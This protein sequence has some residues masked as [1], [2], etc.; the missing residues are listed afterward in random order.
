MEA[1]DLERAASDSPSSDAAAALRGQIALLQAFAPGLVARRLRHDH[2]PPREP[3]SE[4]LH[5]AVLFSDISGFT[6]LTERLARRGARGAEDVKEVINGC[7]GPLIDLIA[8]HGGEVEKFAGD[9]T[10]AIWPADSEAE[11]PQAILCAA[12]CCLEIQ[13][14]LDGLQMGE[15]FQLRLRL[16]LTAGSA[17]LATTGGVDGRWETL[18]TGDALQQI[19]PA[20]RQAAPGD[21]VISPEAWDLVRSQA[22]GELLEEGCL[23]LDDLRPRQPPR[24]AAEIAL[25]EEAVE[26]LRSFVP[27]SVQSRFL[28]GQTGWLAEFR[29]VSV[30][31]VRFGNFELKSGESLDRLHRA[32]RGI[33]G[34]IYHFGG[35]VNQLVTDEKGNCVVAA[36]GLPS[37]HY[38]DNAVRAV[39]AALE[40]GETLAELEVDGSLGLATGQIFTGPRGNDR[41]RDYAMIGNAVNLAARLMQSAGAGILSD[42]ATRQAAAKEIVFDRL[43]PILVKGRSSPVDIFRP[44]ALEKRLSKRRDETFGRDGEKE[45]LASRLTELLQGQGSTVLIEGEPGIGKSHLMM[46]FLERAKERGVQVLLGAGDA[47][48][49]ASAFH[50]WRPV[51]DQL[52]GFDELPDA[53]SKRRRYFERLPAEEHERA[54]LL[55]PILPFDLAETAATAGLT[56]KGRAE[57]RRELLAGILR[58]A[59]A[60]GPLVISIE[61][62]HWLDS[63]SWD[64]LETVHREALGPMLLIG[65]RFLREQEI[66]TECRRLLEHPHLERLQL[67]ALQPS[68]SVELVCRVL[69][70]DALPEVVSRLVLERAE[71]NPLFTEELVYS[72]RDRGLI[73]IENGSCRLAAESASFQA[74]SLPDSAQ[75]VVTSRIDILEPRQQLTLK[76]ASVM[77]RRFDPEI[78]AD[79]HPIAEDRRQIPAHLAALAGLD[80]IQPTLDDADAGYRF[81]HSITQEAAYELLPFAQ[82]RELHR[83]VAVWHEEHRH[84]DDSVFALLAHHWTQAEVPVK[85]LE[86]LEKAGR[87]AERSYAY[88]EVARFFE[89]ALALDA[90]T[91]D[92]GDGDRRTISLPG[93]AVVTTRIARRARWERTLG[94]SKANLGRLEEGAVHLEKVLQLLG[95]RLPATARGYQLA[96]LKEVGR[97]L[98]HRLRPGSNNRYHAEASE[99]LQEMARAYARLGSYYYVSAKRLEFVYSLVAALNAAE[100]AEVSPELAMAYADAGTAAGVVAFHPAARTYTRLAFQSAAKVDQLA[101]SARV[102]SRTSIYRFAI[103]DWSCEADLEESIEM[104]D[105]LGDPYQWEESCFLLAQV[106]LF[107]GRYEESEELGRGVRERA[108]R[109]GTLVHEIWG[110]GIQADCTL[111]LGRLDES[112]DQAEENL[113]LLG[114]D[115]IYPDSVIRTWGVLAL[116]RLRRNEFD[117]ALEAAETAGR[118]I[119]KAARTNYIS[120]Q[121]YSGSADVY[122]TLAERRAGGA[123]RPGEGGELMPRAREACKRLQSY[124]RTY[125]LSEPRDHIWNGRLLALEGRRDKAIA[126]IL[127]GLR[128]AEEIGLPLDVG[129]ACFHL[130]RLD[131]RDAIGFHRRALE[132]YSRHDLPWELEE[133]R[134]LEVRQT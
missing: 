79:V 51:F 132:I 93:G 2:E 28:A 27:N 42:L 50:C 121:G 11:L 94:M 12:Q 36:W 13:Q 114:N 133:T 116:A 62:A 115:S 131:A 29:R 31:F 106:K 85:A 118:E 32:F 43:E 40:I 123:A 127:K 63:A 105:R 86:Y 7:F 23:R 77:G 96:L 95:A 25:G 110:L 8:R 81:K 65:T 16:A 119:A 71:G 92:S 33:Q 24:P 68:A 37:R 46:D 58:R 97:Q 113:E 102:I 52:F 26:A 82:R 66:S 89:K 67:E 53:E 34:A 57:A 60:A 48:E 75:G 74:L 88:E 38:D 84:E 129:L 80:L 104:S 130:A 103:G 98:L 134:R 56:V 109:S 22:V 1:H 73:L 128:R 108:R 17:W 69:D 122:L 47:I 44:V 35:S 91:P 19:T 101:T 21:I 87:Q 9:A 117:L 111:H 41:R 6:A 45:I 126:L 100:L 70:V 124:T 20:I 10:V 30:L 54:P 78:L 72:L 61:D 120:F 125:R 90:Q 5:A 59:A 49:R 55:D 107:T 76:V 15:D 83:S 39:R 99:C 3:R 4:L 14:E 64:L 112:V 18:V